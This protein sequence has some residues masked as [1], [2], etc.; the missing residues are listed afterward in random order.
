MNETPEPLFKQGAEGKLYKIDYQGKP[1]ILKE[2]FQK[3]Y[4]NAE[5]DERLTKERIRAESKSIQRCK[6]VGKT[7]HSIVFSLELKFVSY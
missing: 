4:R 3:K 7:H 6:N 2:R 1:A 5:L